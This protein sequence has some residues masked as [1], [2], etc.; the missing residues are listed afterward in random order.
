MLASAGW[1]AGL[2]GEVLRNG[3]LAPTRSTH[4]AVWPRAGCANAV[5]T[6]PLFEA[7]RR[8]VGL[9]YL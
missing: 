6:F 7:M 3:N 4:L 8:V 1:L 5:L 9:D 2:L